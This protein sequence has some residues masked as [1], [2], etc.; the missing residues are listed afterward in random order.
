MD[1]AQAIGKRPYFLE[2]GLISKEGTSTQHGAKIL[3]GMVRTADRC[4]HG[5][6]DHSAGRGKVCRGALQV[7]P[8]PCG[9]SASIWTGRLLA[10]STSNP[11]QAKGWH[12]EQL[13]RWRPSL[14][15]V[16]C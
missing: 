3:R 13:T 8:D 12:S 2:D 14:S 15:P 11:Q 9:I 5:L 4:I 1:R 10:H 16:R 7:L 6:G